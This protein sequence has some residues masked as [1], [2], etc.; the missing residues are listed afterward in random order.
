MTWRYFKFWRFALSKSR[1][2]I[3]RDSEGRWIHILGPL[4]ILTDR[5]DALLD[6][7]EVERPRCAN[8]Q[9]GGE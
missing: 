7:V 3:M 8:Q 2:G 1:V 4:W 9:G 5:Y 6:D